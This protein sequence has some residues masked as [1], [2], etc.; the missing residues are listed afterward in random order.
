MAFV[1]DVCACDDYMNMFPFYF[2]SFRDNKLTFAQARVLNPD[3]GHT[4]G[5]LS[6]ELQEQKQSSFLEKL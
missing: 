6:A 1:V 3:N 4:A 5:V 2:C